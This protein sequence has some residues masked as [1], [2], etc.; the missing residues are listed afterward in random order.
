M[1]RC[2]LRGHEFRIFLPVSHFG[3]TE[4]SPLEYQIADQPLEASP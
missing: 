2:T 4:A 3:L 1:N